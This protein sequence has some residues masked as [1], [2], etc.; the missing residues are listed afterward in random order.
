[1][2]ISFRQATPA[3][4]D[5]CA[6]LYFAAMEATIRALELDIAKHT[7]SFRERWSAAETR[8]ITRD[9]ADIGWLQAAAEGDAVFLKQLFVDAPLRRRGIGTQVMHRLIDEAGGEDR[10]VTLGVVKANPALRLYRRLGFAITHEDER[11]L[12]MRRERDGA[13]PLRR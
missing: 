7:V 10:A 4:F 13:G 9:G 5:Y 12:Y 2:Q 11:K 6:R 8:I 3:D 1:V